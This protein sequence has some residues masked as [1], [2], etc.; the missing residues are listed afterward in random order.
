MIIHLM[1]K[2][3][4]KKHKSLKEIKFQIYSQYKKTKQA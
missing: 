4:I 1:E 2:F 3:R